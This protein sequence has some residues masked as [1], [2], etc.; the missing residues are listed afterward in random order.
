MND[1][2]N[3]KSF[4]QALKSSGSHLRAG[5]GNNII[6]RLKEIAEKEEVMVIVY[7]D[8]ELMQGRISDIKLDQLGPM[9]MGTDEHPKAVRL[10]FEILEKSPE[11]SLRLEAGKILF[12]AARMKLSDYS[13]EKVNMVKESLKSGLIS[14]DKAER[15]AS[16][17]CLFK[18]FGAETFDFCAAALNHSNPDVRFETARIFGFLKD[19]RAVPMLVEAL[20]TESLP[21]GRSVILWALGYMKDPRALPALIESLEDEDAEAGGYAAWALGEIGGPEAIDALKAAMNDISKKRE[22]QAWA[23]RGL[24]A[25]KSKERIEVSDN[26]TEVEKKSSQ[27]GSGELICFYCGHRNPAGSRWCE[28]DGSALR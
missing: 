13:M 12:T 4:L 5:L 25:A 27:Q 14:S 23:A 22:V 7:F 16:M 17:W 26:R 21:K 11:E 3:E 10:L 24:L 6:S 1:D 20:E 9:V 18:L 28:I 2:S 19:N 8:I 15:S